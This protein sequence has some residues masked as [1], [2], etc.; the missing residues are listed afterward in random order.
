MKINPLFV[1]R[2]DFCFI[3]L[4]TNLNMRNI[5]LLIL[6]ILFCNS[7]LAQFSERSTPARWQRGR[8][9]SDWSM[10]KLGTRERYF[11]PKDNRVAQPWMEFQMDNDKDVRRYDVSDFDW[12][13]NLGKSSVVKLLK[14]DIS[15]YNNDRQN[16]NVASGG[17]V[18]QNY[19]GNNGETVDES[20]EVAFIDKIALNLDLFADCSE[21]DYEMLDFGQ[22]DEIQ[23]IGKRS[24]SADPVTPLEDDVIILS[25][26]VM[27]L[28]IIKS[29]FG[30][31]R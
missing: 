3:T 14:S 1:W 30:N 10:M 20:M 25:L 29:R 9:S 27:A 8:M 18:Q 15:L 12:Q 28:V 26:M 19:V 5:L 24:A 6:S 13:Y 22:D 16:G 11:M 4:H 7:L 23:K 21:S 17:Q 2:I 31:G